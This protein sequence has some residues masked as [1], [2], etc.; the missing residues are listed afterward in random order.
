MKLF[1]FILLG[2][3]SFSL[4][5]QRQNEKEV[6]VT[7]KDSLQFVA[8]VIEAEKFFITD[9][10]EKALESFKIALKL[11]ENAAAVHFK[12]AE[13]LIVLDRQQEAIPYCIKAV[14][15]SP[16][17]KYYQLLL[18]RTYR[19]LSF[20][21]EAVKVYEALIVL[22]PADETALY[23]LA[24]L[25]STIGDQKKMLL[26]FDKI[27]ETIGVK[28]EIIR[29]RQQ[30]Y[31]KKGDIDKVIEEYEKL[32]K[33]FVNEPFYRLEFIDFLIQNNE[34]ERAK[35]EIKAYEMTEANSSQIILQKSSLAWAEKNYEKALDLLNES[36]E[37]S[38]WNFDKKLKILSSYILSINTPQQKEQ[39]KNIVVKLA[40]KHPTEYK[41]QALAAD[42]YYDAGQKE[43][44]LSYYLKS[45]EI[46]SNNFSVWQNILNIE[47]ELEMYR[48]VITHAEQALELFPNQ[49]FLYYFAGFAYSILNDVDRS[50][51]MLEQGKVFTK[52]PSLLTVFYGQL[53]D[54]YHSNN[55][56]KKSYNAYE[57]ALKYAPDNDHVLNNYS[58]YLSLD[59]KDLDKA[60]QMSS[61]L[62]KNHPENS[63]YLDTHGWVLYV[64]EN[65]KEAKKFLEKAA[66]Y[67]EDGT[68]IEH[69]GDVLYKLGKKTEAVTQWKKARNLG[70]TSTRINEKINNQ[71]LYE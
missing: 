10:M 15:L 70:G 8:M 23:E 31:M 26:I 16:S 21:Q 42:L 41:A 58:Y 44:A 38:V 3:C 1:L 4:F 5:S 71:K 19:S 14:E 61:K 22:Y 25:Y 56:S 30:I 67:S 7:G 45:I 11:N 46:E 49:A 36:L 20:Y 64:R 68:I 65:Y 32:I 29:E 28:E 33:A 39:I 62:I 27:E 40:A 69:L 24:E 63:T 37:K 52:D 53:G 17:Q 50:I 60:L 12:I 43:E 35:K 6:M 54:A 48:E 51:R 66:K 59:K 13:I 9:R 18:A 2:F 55:N 47:S 34:I 57:Q